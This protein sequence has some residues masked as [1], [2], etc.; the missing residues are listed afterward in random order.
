[1]AVTLF[2]LIYVAWLGNFIT[3]INFASA[4]GRYFVM[5]L[6]VVTKFTDIGAYLTARRFAGTK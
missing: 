3:R 5:L 6:V 4:Q 1:M 2:G